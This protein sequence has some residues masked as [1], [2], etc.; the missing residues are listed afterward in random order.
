MINQQNWHQVKR[1]E[2]LYSTPIA[3]N[4]TV[5][6]NFFY[7]AESGGLLFFIRRHFHTVTI[8]DDVTPEQAPWYCLEEDWGRNDSNKAED[9]RVV[10][11]AIGYHKVDHGQ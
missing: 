11:F 2:T 8:A 1:L 3:T 9:H 4:S 6:Q 5:A 10:I 7:S